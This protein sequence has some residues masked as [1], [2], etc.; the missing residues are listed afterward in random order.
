M[1]T[2]TPSPRRSNNSTRTR[3]N[4]FNRVGQVWELDGCMFV[5]TE[6]VKKSAKCWRHRMME[7]DSGDTMWTLESTSAA[8]EENEFCERVQ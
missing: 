5:I 4:R 6:S 1:N 3:F 8:M 7:M 2:P